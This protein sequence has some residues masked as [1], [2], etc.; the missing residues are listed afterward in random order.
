M[1]RRDTSLW[2]IQTRMPDF[3]R[4]YDLIYL[5][6]QLYHFCLAFNSEL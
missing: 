5:P 1:Y 3:L 6:E 4:L 2:G